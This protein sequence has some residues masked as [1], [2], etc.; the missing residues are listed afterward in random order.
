MAYSEDQIKELLKEVVDP[1]T[2][3]N[4]INDKSIKSISIKDDHLEIKVLL[5]YPAKSQLDEIKD[6]I[7]NQIKKDLP[8]AHLTIDI[9]FKIIEDFLYFKISN[10]IPAITNFEQQSN[11]TSGIGLNN[12]KK[13]LELGYKKEHYNLTLKNSNNLFIVELKIKVS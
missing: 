1:N 6:L 3:D 5:G 11:A 9:D 7:T 2:R 13:R 10:P 4:L 8:K 12:V